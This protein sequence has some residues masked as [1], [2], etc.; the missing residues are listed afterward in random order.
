MSNWQGNRAE[1]FA[2]HIVVWIC[3]EVMVGEAIDNLHMGGATVLKV[4]APT[5]W[6][7]GGQNIA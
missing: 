5:F 3:G 6:P 2:V 1:M 4:G 7:V